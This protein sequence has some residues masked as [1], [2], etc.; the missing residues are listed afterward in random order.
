MKNK[1][2]L[3]VWGL[4]GLVVATMLRA[5][6]DPTA[7]LPL[8]ANGLAAAP[9]MGWNS[10]NKFAC[11]VNEQVVRA[12]VD[13]MVDSGMQDVGYRYVVIDDCWQ[14]MRAP[15][16]A[17]EADPDRF[18]RGIKALADYVHSKGLL[19]GI[20][21][22]AGSQSCAGRAG[23]RGHEFQDAQR[24]AAWGID[25]LKYDWCHT[26]SQDAPSSYR[27]MALALRATGRP[28]LFSACEWGQA[29]PWLWAADNGVN[30]WRVGPDIM[31]R[32]SGRG[33]YQLGVLDIV[34]LAEP[35]HA[36]AGPGHWNDPDM[37]EVGNGGMTEVEYR[38]HF[39]LWAEMAAPLIAGNDL[40]HMTPTTRVLL[41]N[42]E[43]IAID[44]DRL[45]AQGHRVAR[46]GD[47]EVWSKPLADGGRAVL[48]FNRGD[49]ATTITARWTDLGYPAHVTATLRDVWNGKDLPAVSGAFSADVEAHG[50]VMV[51]VT[52]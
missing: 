10:W 29:R 30:L 44:Q 2:L 46:Q 22:D 16:G 4:L 45:G 35:R 49:R 28:I 15:D 18:P 17:I 31:D 38:S 33:D 6:P 3:I 51:T 26:G 13:A 48:L 9:P 43:V 37:L 5:D 12:A 27:T 21:S 42:R 39:S 41:T 32:W 34:D 20:Y 36:A 19:L 40:A 23:S 47:G 24:F 8:A 52:P 11:G 14:G 50:V 25:Y 7:M 1:A